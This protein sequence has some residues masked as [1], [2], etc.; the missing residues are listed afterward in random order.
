MHS[1]PQPNEDWYLIE[2]GQREG[3]VSTARMMERLEAQIIDRDTPVWRAGLAGWK[4]VSETELA[5]ALRDTPPP[6]APAHLNNTLV[7]II[8]LAPSPMHSSVASST[9][10]SRRHP[11]KYIYISISWTLP[12]RGS[13][14]Q[15]SASG[16]NVRSARPGTPTAGSL[17]SA[18]SW[19][20]FT[21]SFA[22]GG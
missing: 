1:E 22:P 8:A 13:S 11:N 5:S 16:T 18:C 20:P 4:P 10:Q 21:F 17:S 2:R 12:C 19:R 15:S 9:A 7:W 3:P 14:T 6:V